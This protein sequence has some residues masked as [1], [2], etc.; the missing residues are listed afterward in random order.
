MNLYVHVPFCARRCSYCDFSI[1]VR[2]TV[3]SQPV[4]RDRF[5]GS[6]AACRTTPP[7]PSSPELD[8]VYFGGGT[9][10]HLDPA[11]LAA[12]LDGLRADRRLSPSA[13]VTLEANPD[14]VTEAAAAAWRESGIG[15][16]SLGVQ[17]FSPAVLT[18]M[19]RT[20]TA[21]QALTRCEILR[22]VGF[23]D[24]S[25]DL[26]YGLPAELGRDWAADL[27]QA[28][29]LGPDHLS[30]YG[31]TVEAHTP[32]RPL[33]RARPGRRRWTKSQYADEFLRLSGTLAE[34]GWEHYEVS[35]AARPG[36][37]A[38]HNSGYWSGAPYLGLG[39]SA[40][41]GAG[42]ERRWNIREYAAWDAAVREGRDPVA[43]RE[44]LDPAQRR[45]EAL[46]LGLRTSAG[47]PPRSGA[48]SGAGALGG[49]GVG[50]RG[51]G[52]A[53]ALRRGVA[54]ARRVGGRGGLIRFTPMASAEHLSSRQLHVL[55]AVIQTYIETAEPAGSRTI[56]QRF[57]LG[58]SPATVRNIMSEL[59]D[60]GLLYHPHT[61]AGRIPTDLAYRVYVDSLMHL[62]PPSDEARQTLQDELPGSRNAMDQ[63][64]RR[65]AQVL[66]VLTQELG[67]AVAPAFE[68]IVL[69]RLELVQVSSERILMVLTLRSGAVRTVFVEV[70]GAI[71]KQALD[72]V[73]QVLNER[74]AGL[75]VEEIR[76]S[77][78]D[79]LRDAGEMPGEPRAAQHL[80]RRARRDSSTFPGR[81]R[82]WC[83]AGR[84][85]WPS[86]RSSRP[87]RRCATCCT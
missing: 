16:V 1:A 77:L 29:A 31:L 48:G 35:N 53:A 60:K 41:S 30:C 24:I 69:E 61:S 25:L 74:L 84:N 23:A 67:V 3:P 68:H 40:H 32:A 27:D 75:T 13:E 85:C 42:A 2:R 86:S 65:T 54:P 79:R 59:E 49:G 33:D 46:Y 6:G 26:I 37:R 81:G 7:G 55:E 52:P 11:A 50:G 18:W 80:H 82:R 36:H 38:R 87:T 5:S 45:L 76:S 64:L 51:R 20:H 71:A 8:T 70:R 57:G 17:S 4:R 44:R 72:R 39:P 19:H 21:Q 28:F 78:A 62:A 43:G 9:P 15:R 83:W 63:L 56:A 22:A 66:G 12:I 34:L 47:V 10:S 73:A 14:D 58:V